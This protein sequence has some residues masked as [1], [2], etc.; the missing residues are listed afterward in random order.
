MLALV[1][2]LKGLLDLF[3]RYTTYDRGVFDAVF[4]LSNAGFE[5]LVTVGT[6]L[7]ELF[8]N[9][10]ALNDLL[11]Q[12]VKELDISSWV[13]LNVQ[14]SLF[15][16]RSYT[17]VTDQDV[18]TLFLSLHDSAAGKRVGF[19]VV[20][21]NDKHEVCDCKVVKRVGRCTGSKDHVQTGDG[22][23]VAQTGT[24]VDVRGL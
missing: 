11:H 1:E 24:V 8:I 16:G 15:G 23:C 6:V 22:R 4:V 5:F 10:A 13:V 18:G 12:A 17:R 14:V 9:P 19:E 2:P 7:H 20:R 3:C 21:T